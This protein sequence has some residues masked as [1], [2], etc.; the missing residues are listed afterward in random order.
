MKKQVMSFLALF[1]LV[2]V[3]SIYYVLLPTNL[4]IDN[5]IENVL[6]VNMNIE[7]SSNLFFVSLDNE[8]Q[9]KHN[10]KIYEYESIV[11]LA[12]Y[13]N[14]EKEVALNK[15]NNR[16]KMME[17]EEMLVGLIKDLGYY[18]AYVEYLDDMIKVVVQSDGLSTVQ[19]AEIITLVM[20][21]SVNGL[22]PCSSM[23]II[24]YLLF[25]SFL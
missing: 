12:N 13:T 4:F 15:L 16:V 8:L 5:N 7:E 18:N 21:N 11:A 25:L 3:L 2:F 19:A 9:E 20:D 17:N 10:E 23:K 22:L 1:G 6:D 14:E 24:Y